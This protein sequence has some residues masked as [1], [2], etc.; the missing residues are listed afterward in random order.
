M[1][2]HLGLPDDSPHVLAIGCHADD[3]EIGCGGTLL[4]LLRSRDDV[5]VTWLVL[6]AGEERAAEARTSAEAFLAGARTKDVIVEEFRDGF[7]PY[8]GPAVKETFE[9]LKSLPEPDLI[10]TH[11][12][13]D[14]HQDHRLACELTWNTFRRHLILEFEIPKYD[15]DMS[16][17]NFFVPIDE[18]VAHEKMRLLHDHFVTQQTKHWFDGE[19]FLG[20]LRLR[21]AQANVPGRYAEAFHCRKITFAL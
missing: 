15:G 1:E 19:L 3:I 13:S 7:L 17:P 21:G 4:T 2:A 11:T 10:F 9:Q 16:N 5:H 12:E 14:R 20:L 18:D 8:L 6:A